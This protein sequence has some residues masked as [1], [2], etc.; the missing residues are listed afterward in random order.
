MKKST[1]N[2]RDNQFE[3]LKFTVEVFI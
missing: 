3:I 2:S 1:P